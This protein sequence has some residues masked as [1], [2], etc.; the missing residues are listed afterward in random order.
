MIADTK[1]WSEEVDEILAGDL[2]AALGYVTPAGGVVVTPVCPFGRRDRSS[3][4]VEFTTPLALGTKLTRIERNPKVALF[5]Y[6]RDHGHAQR[7]GEVLIQGDATFP[8]VPD[9]EGLERLFGEDVVRYLGPQPAGPGWAWL[10]REYYWIRV[11]VTI[12]ARSARTAVTPLEGLTSQER[13]VGGTAP[14]V[15]VRAAARRATRFG[16]C[17]VGFV[18]RDGYPDLR[19]VTIRGWNERG[20]ELGP[21]S[22]LPPG[23]QRAGLLSHRFGRQVTKQGVSVHTGWLTVDE[24]GAVYAPHTDVHYSVPGGKR[25]QVLAAG[26]DTKLRMR[27]MRKK[28]LVAGDRWVPV[29]QRSVPERE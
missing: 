27:T 20:L 22:A 7:E 5:F 19:P 25:T 17:V 1:H 16:N 13:P 21:L 2:I 29:E 15:S 18:N 9:R 23:G 26:L 6:L 12:Q 11:P 10:T 4:A 3:G 28:G 14:R 24:S 8:H